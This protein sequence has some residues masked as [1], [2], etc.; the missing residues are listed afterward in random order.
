MQGK[1]IRYGKGGSKK[2]KILRYL[3]PSPFALFIVYTKISKKIGDIAMEKIMDFAQHLANNWQD[4]IIAGVIVCCVNVFLTG[5]F[6]NLVGNRVTNAR[7]RKVLLFSF[8]ILLLA[9]VV[10]AYLMIAGENL[11]YF[12]GCYLA[13][14]PAEIVFYAFYENSLL[15]DFVNFVAKKFIGKIAPVVLEGMEKKEPIEKKA[16]IALSTVK[17][18]VTNKIKRSVD[19]DLENL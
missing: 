4:V 7:A 18:D 14:I 10:F 19:S 9:P 2:E 6:K 16:E 12:V 1:R 15:R 3:Q 17:E 5:V 8:S 11:R 13:V